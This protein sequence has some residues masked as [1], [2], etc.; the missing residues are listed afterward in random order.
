MV[1]GDPEEEDCY[2][3]FALT[4]N[5]LEPYKVTMN[6]EGSD[7]NMELD[8]GASKSIMS[9]ETYKSLCGRSKHLYIVLEDTSV[10][11]RT[12]T[13]ESLNVLGL[14]TVKVKYN[15]QEAVLPLLVIKGNSPS[16]LGRDWLYKLRQEINTV[17][18]LDL[19]QDLL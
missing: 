12:Y 9:E 14:M 5:S 2:T 18:G 3:M 1:K 15:Q 8:T 10:R 11:L 4:S 16:L 17:R 6:I 13:G 19:S 7:L